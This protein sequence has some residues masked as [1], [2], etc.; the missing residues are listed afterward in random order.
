MD[1]AF[2]PEQEDLR[3]TVRQFLDKAS[4]G[5]E[6]RR[7]MATDRGYHADAWR[8]LADELGLLG[9]AVPEKYGG[10]G[11]GF[12][13]IGIV[14]QEMGR[15]L[16]CGPFLSTVVLAA[17]ALLGSADE[18]ARRRWLPAIA[19][20]ELIATVA[21]NIQVHGGIGYTWE[22]P[23]HLYFRRATTSRMW[24]GDPAGHHERLLSQLGY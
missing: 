5:P 20:G 1:F 18:A 3:R 23:A 4:P 19:A 9:M 22:H 8:R 10:A 14:A 17:A 16:F 12:T 6:V 7:V 13:E 2:T 24:L 11:A 21:E 15:A